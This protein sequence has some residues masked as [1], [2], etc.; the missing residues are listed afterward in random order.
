MDEEKN[1]KLSEI[2]EIY[3]KDINTSI[4]GP[5][6]K[7]RG[8][9]ILKLI[10]LSVLAVSLVVWLV[11][12]IISNVQSVPSGSLQFTLEAPE[13]SVPG[14]SVSY[15]VR[16][17]N[18]DQSTVEDAK[19]R[20]NYPDG[21]VFRDS[22]IEPEQGPNNTWLL[23]EIQPGETVE[24]NIT[25]ALLGDSSAPRVLFGLVNYELEGF[26]SRLELTD[27]V[28]TF[29][30]EQAVTLDLLN[31]DPVGTGKET[32]LQIVV[33]NIG[34]E[35]LRDL[36]VVIELLESTIVM[37][38]APLTEES[39]DN[40]KWGLDVLEAGE[41]RLYK[42]VV[43][44][45]EQLTGEFSVPATLEAISLAGVKYALAS[46]QLELKFTPPDISVVL[47]LD[48]RQ[49]DEVLVSGR[50]VVVVARIKNNS[51]ENVSIKGLK[52]DLNEDFV[53]WS[54]ANLAGGDRVDG[55]IVWASGVLGETANIE[56]NEEKRFT[57][58]MPILDSVA[59]G[60][61]VKLSVSLI[62]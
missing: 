15:I 1:N 56:P 54:A 28:T 53:N 4:M 29:L 2:E 36:S 34:D 21:F 40:I 6:D 58:V 45:P 9:T 12:F 23:S 17:E 35:D 43:I 10:A 31:G 61:Q 55:A 49:A 41:K 46:D 22:S 38:T 3:Q 47:E 44:W 39:D 20:L 50:D 27:S 37:G 7:K 59:N 33:Q 16:L 18:N 57:W 52:L 30:G 19:V 51:D 60:E 26:R 48:G 25:G 24:I 42:V 5:S 8:G 11:Y 14:G 13:K 32:E 62:E